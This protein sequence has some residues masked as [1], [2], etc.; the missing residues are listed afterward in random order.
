MHKH[1]FP[2]SVS[3]ADA[4]IQQ[5]LELADLTSLYYRV[6]GFAMKDD[7]NWYDVLSPGEMQRLSFVRLFFHKPK[8]AG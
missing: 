8:F 6:G 1:C 4:K 7:I 5:N 3:N 2:I